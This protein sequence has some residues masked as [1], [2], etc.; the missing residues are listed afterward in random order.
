M[1][2]R[3]NVAYGWLWQYDD[4]TIGP[5]ILHDVER[6]AGMVSGWTLDGRKCARPLSEIEALSTD[7]VTWQPTSSLLAQVPQE[8]HA[9]RVRKIRDVSLPVAFDEDQ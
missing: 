5:F 8:E 9:S 4:D 3:L 2:A 1:Y 7:G 6:Y